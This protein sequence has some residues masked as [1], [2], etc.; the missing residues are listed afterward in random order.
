MVDLFDYIYTSIQNRNKTL[1]RIRV[2]SFLR[3]VVRVSA[4]IIIPVYFSLTRNNKNYSIRMSDKNS[5][6]VIVSMTSF[7]LRIKRIWLVIESI[8]RQSRKPD[9]IILWL[10]KEQFPSFNSLPAKLLKQ[11]NRGLEI[12]L[13]EGDLRSHKKYFYAIQEFPDDY[14][15]TVDDDAFYHS[16][17]LSFLIDLNNKYPI[18]ICCNSARYIASETGELLPYTHWQIVKTQQEPGTDII[19]IGQGGILY[20][21]HSLHNNVID[22]AVFRKYCFLADDIWLNVM[23]RL[24]GTNV[25]KT[26]YYSEYL[27]VLNSNDITLTSVNV[28]EGLNDIQ[29]K[30]VRDYCIKVLEID[31]YKSNV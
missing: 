10:S 14:I 27:P 21:P 24:K 15:I 4:N 7:P 3:F 22:E 19:P 30:S 5:G 23:A 6:R 11:I 20:P 29:L 28:N 1:T 18:T 13:V 26:S 25:A 31:P 9:K 8:L 16:K 2:Y 12:R 17:L